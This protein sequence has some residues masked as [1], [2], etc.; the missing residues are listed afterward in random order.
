MAQMG[1][2][3][4]IGVDEVGRGCLA[5]PVLAAAVLMPL[6][7]DYYFRDSKL[8]NKKERLASYRLIKK[9]AFS[10]KIG[11]ASVQEI[12]NTNILLATNLAMKRAVE[13]L[14]WV[15]KIVLVDGCHLPNIENCNLKAIVKGDQT[16]SQIAAAS[17]VAK[18]V[19]DYLMTRI[20]RNYPGYLFENHKG[21]PTKAHIFALK[22]L[23][24][25]DLHRKTFRPV[26]EILRKEIFQ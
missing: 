11:A 2:E 15:G 12:D 23:G 13:K 14:D 9:Y 3:V 8:L 22:N 21:Y 5:G 26:K 10:V 25:T 1:N 20:S 17:I 7:T 19:R 6:K 4:V 16:Y 24:V 18:V